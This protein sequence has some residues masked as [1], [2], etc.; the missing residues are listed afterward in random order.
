MF[1]VPRAFV[2]LKRRKF[3]SLEQKVNSSRQNQPRRILTAIGAT[4]AR[5][6]Q[7]YF[8]IVGFFSVCVTRSLGRGPISGRAARAPQGRVFEAIS[9]GG[10][11]TQRSGYSCRQARRGV[12]FFGERLPGENSGF[13]VFQPFAFDLSGGRSARGWRSKIK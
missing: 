3:C 11:W 10:K 13:G 2:L 9:R 8:V 4:V 1:L 7:S 6:V 5:F 12:R